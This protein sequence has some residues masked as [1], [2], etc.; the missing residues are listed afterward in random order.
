LLLYDIISDRRAQHARR[1]Q[2]GSTFSSAAMPHATTRRSE[3]AT[4]HLHMLS[5]IF[6]IDHAGAF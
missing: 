5:V 4:A 2:L 3:L 6:S 1:K